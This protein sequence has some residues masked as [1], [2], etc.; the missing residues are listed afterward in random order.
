MP[1]RKTDPQRPAA[2][3]DDAASRPAGAEPDLAAEAESEVEVDD[4]D[5]EPGDVA[6]IPEA[7]LLKDPVKPR[8]GAKRAAGNGSLVHARVSLLDRYLHEVSRYKLLTREQ[9]FELAKRFQT[10]ADPA[11]A[12]S[13]VTA[14]LRFVVKIA[15]EYRN[16]NVKLVD[17]I[18]EGNI[19]L[20]MAVKKFNADRGY[21]LISYAVWW[22]KAYMQNYI[23]KNWSM[24]K[25]PLGRKNRMLLAEIM[26]KGRDS[27]ADSDDSRRQLV[28]DLVFAGEYEKKEDVRRILDQMVLASRDFYLDQEMDSESGRTYAATLAS[29]DE[30]QDDAYS[31]SELRD[32]LAKSLKEIGPTLSEKERFILKHRILEDDPRTLQEIGDKFA[33]SRERVRQ[34]ENNLKK[35]LRKN[36]QGHDVTVFLD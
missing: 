33:I 16:Y 12:H 31:R 23:I 28:D 9:E 8:R 24:S 17:L 35:K 27:G 15:Y 5:L 20:M 19:G 2:S 18:Q 6:D 3:G 7:E 11:L 1:R 32:V 25:I 26:R 4:L 34:I 13:M 22:I 36:L 10:T 21:R 14:N 29:E 30:S